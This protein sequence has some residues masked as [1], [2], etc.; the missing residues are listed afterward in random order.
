MTGKIK[1]EPLRVVWDDVNSICL[2]RDKREWR[3][4]ACIVGNPRAP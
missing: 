3:T 1:I 4:V 2:A